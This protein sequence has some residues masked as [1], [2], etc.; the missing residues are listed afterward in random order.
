[1]NVVGLAVDFDEFTHSVFKLPTGSARTPRRRGA[2][3]A[4][5]EEHEV[6]PE[7]ELAMNPG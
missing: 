5:R 3:K 4:V 1:M 2:K 6:L 7:R